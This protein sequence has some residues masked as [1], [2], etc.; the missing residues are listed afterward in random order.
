MSNINIIK[1]HHFGLD[2]GMEV[3]MTLAEDLAKQ[4]GAEYVVRGSQVAFRATGIEGLVSL[5][6]H[7]IQIEAKLGFLMSALKGTIEN[8]IHHKIDEILANDSKDK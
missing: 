6:D 5:S 4:Y 7:D 1:P 2:K 3:M 8:Q